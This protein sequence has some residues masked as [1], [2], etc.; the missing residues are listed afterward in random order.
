MAFGDVGQAYNARVGTRIGTMQVGIPPF[1]LIKVML[2]CRHVAT[3]RR[4]YPKLK[5]NPP[6]YWPNVASMQLRR[7]YT[8]SLPNLSTR[9]PHPP[10]AHDTAHTC[11][12]HS[13]AYSP[14]CP[15]T[16]P[17]HSPAL[18][19]A[20]A[21]PANTARKTPSRTRYTAPPSRP[22]APRLCT[23]RTHAWCPSPAAS[24]ALTRV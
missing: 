21:H 11:P 5:N 16:R 3:H 22:A 1:G 24:T 9:T 20:P 18:A 6:V 4:A 13:T 14:P 23:P 19:P 7:A 2:R 8:V 12:V 10:D 15:S 17:C